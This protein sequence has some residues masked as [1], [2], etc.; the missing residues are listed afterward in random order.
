MHLRIR[1]RDQLS[2]WDALRN[3]ASQPGSPAVR[4]NR[5]LPSGVAISQGQSPPS[6]LNRRPSS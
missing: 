4:V 2:P 3:A 6:T 1:V 5:R